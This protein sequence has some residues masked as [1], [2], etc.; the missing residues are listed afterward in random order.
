MKRLVLHAGMHKT[1]TTAVQS[2]AAKNRDDLYSKGVYYP[3]S[4]EFF[5]NRADL[6]SANAHFSLFNALAEDR[7]RDRKNLER[8]RRHLL[9]E[10]PRDMTILLSAE[11]MN[12]HVIP[13][14]T[15]FAAGH[16]AYLDRMAAYFEAFHTEVVIY[17]RQPGGFAES[18]FSE[19]AV[20][21]PG[22]VDFDKAPRRYAERF[23]YRYVQ[24]SYRAHFP[25]SCQ[26]F[27]AQKA[28]LTS[29]FWTAL[30]LPAPADPRETTRRPSVPKAAVMWIFQAK[31]DLGEDMG[32]PERLRRWLFGLQ[33]ENA[34]IFRSDE[35]TTFWSDPEKR[36]A[37]HRRMT[38]GFT[39]I[40]FEEPG[41]LPPRCTWSAEDHA[42]AETRFQAWLTENAAWLKDRAE[43]RIAPFVDPQAPAGTPS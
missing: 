38:D 2:V 39:G 36:A 5:G 24:D 37:F 8:F 40:A 11:S 1:G 17:F 27:E 31:K 6:P 9:D 18:M 30:D 12:R 22:H 28:D 7:P 21:S 3:K 33:Q 42:R 34:D 43:R 19:A 15:D 14:E 10:I 32:R 35:K 13:G 29:A 16:R 20:S 26:S 23:R 4:W 25:V 41:P